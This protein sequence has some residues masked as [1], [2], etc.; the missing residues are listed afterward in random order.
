MGMGPP[1]L[2]EGVLRLSLPGCGVVS[3]PGF[4]FARGRK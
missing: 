1:S 2:A 3:A 4:L